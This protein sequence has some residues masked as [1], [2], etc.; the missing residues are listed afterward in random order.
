MK[1]ST[2]GRLSSHFPFSLLGTSALRQ[3]ITL[4]TRWS[5]QPGE[6]L[7]LT[8]QWPLALC[9]SGSFL[10]EL[11]RA[12][13]SYERG[14]CLGLQRW[15]N[16]SSKPAPLPR[17]IAGEQGGVVLHISPAQLRCFAGAD[18]EREQSHFWIALGRARFQALAA[19]R[20]DLGLP[21]IELRRRWCADA[22]W[23]GLRQQAGESFQLKGA[24]CWFL[25]E[26][27]VTLRTPFQGSLAAPLLIPTPWELTGES[28]TP[29]LWLQ[30]SSLP[31]N[32]QFKERA[33]R[34]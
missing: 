25:Y 23:S 3:L 31:P 18:R 7:E 13:G 24:G 33:S 34:C 26:G 14:A 10:S 32:R 20:T 6:M 2:G 11:S 30:G 12:H 5:Y 28:E 4:G 22:S 27:R 9:L 16:G 19:R 15:L 1:S 29:C 21:D 17:F 8:D